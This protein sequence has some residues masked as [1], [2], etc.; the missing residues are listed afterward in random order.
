[1]RQ[2]VMERLPELPRVNSGCS[3]GAHGVR[4]AQQ[5]ATL[6]G[7]QQS[8]LLSIEAGHAV[9]SRGMPCMNPAGASKPALRLSQ[10]WARSPTC[11][12]HE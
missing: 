11:V 8:H 2:A 5:C 6:H 12:P 7:P 1:M 10:R 9:F 4:A 3:Q